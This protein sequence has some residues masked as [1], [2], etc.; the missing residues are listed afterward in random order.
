MRLMRKQKKT[1]NNRCNNSQKL[2]SLA[3]TVGLVWHVVNEQLKKRN[4]R[5]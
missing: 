3:Q 2:G 1:L 4:K 5:N